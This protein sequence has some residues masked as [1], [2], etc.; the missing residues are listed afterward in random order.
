MAE[1]NPVQIVLNDNDYITAPEP[2]RSGPP[3]DFFAGRDAAFAKHKAKLAGRLSEVSK[4]LEKVGV[5]GQG[6]IKVRLRE[7]ALAKSHRP[8]RSMF[9]PSEFPCVGAAGLGE[10]FYLAS[11]K[12]IGGLINVVAEAELTT[13]WVEGRDGKVRAQPSKVRSDVGAIEDVSLPDPI[14]K[15]DFDAKTA[16]SWL[17]DPRTGGFY[18]VELFEN[19]VLAQRRTGRSRGRLAESVQ[20]LFSQLGAGVVAWPMP[21]AGGELPL[22]L[23]LTLSQDVAR[24][25][26]APSNEGLP[27]EI[28][29]NPARH[30][31]ALQHLASHPAVRRISL[32]LRLELSTADSAP[33]SR[34][35]AVPV[36]NPEVNY[37]KIGVIDTGLGPALH[38]WVIG[39]HDYLDETEVDGEHGSFVGGLLVGAK[40]LNP[41]IPGLEDDGCELVDLALFPQG[42]FMSTYPGGFIDFLHEMDQ[43]IK[44]ASESHGV[45]VFNLSINAVSAVEPDHYSYYAARMDEIAAKHDVV[46]VNSAGN[47]DGSERRAPWPK[48]PIDAIKYF[49]ARVEPDTIHKP[50]ESYRAIS[51]GAL[52][53]PGCTVH[54]EGLPTTYT[55]RGPGL[56]VG[57]KPDVAHYGG[58]DGAGPSGHHGLVSLAPDGALMSDC[59]TS[60]AAPLVAKSLASLESRIEGRMP[61]HALRALL[62][63][64]CFTPEALQDK[65]LAHLARQFVGFGVPC[66]TSQ[67]L[68]TDDSSITLVFTS[69]L[70]DDEKRPKVLRFPF[71]WPQ[72][73]VDPSTG[74]CLGEATATLVYEPPVDRAFG[75][76][77]VRINLDAKLQQRQLENCKDGS[78]S[79]HDRFEQCFLPKTSKQP[80]PE[81]ELIKQGLKWWPTKRYRT[82]FAA[83][84]AGE[85]SEWRIEV[86]AL[87]RAEAPFPIEGVPFSLVVT[88]R[89]PSGVQP[90]FQ[91]LRR[92][93]Q[94]SRVQLEDLRTHQRVRTGG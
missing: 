38:D 65:R 27:V 93:L 79:F 26:S 54:N 18:I 72:A 7:E 6:Y 85:S 46:I 15:R 10:L 40:A 61:S 62:I 73:L 82:R 42:D 49:A 47:L 14:A 86:S 34:T 13:N 84:G 48:K 94:T 90:I 30:E 23:R 33:L 51:V 58:N 8:I 63:H 74:A 16:V 66:P 1:N 2:G 60:F 67:M 56:R 68:L 9:V 12:N 80:V 59:G 41:A 52:N 64:N 29:P 11:A 32:P 4:T 69:R 5:D 57:C 22:A 3:F 83:V 21:A 25:V 92:S 77:F 45:R 70:P 31:Q 50:T 91:Q 35:P 19:P 75:A 36:P 17:S 37:P 39:R 53:P 76:E 87:R 24:L 71:Q 81:K 89:D 78:P 44:E 43:A 88:I 20:S 28:D 55:R